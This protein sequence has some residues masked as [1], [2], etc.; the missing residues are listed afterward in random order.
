MIVRNLATITPET[1]DQ[2]INAI[3]FYKTIREQNEHQYHLLLGHSRLIHYQS[4]EAIIERGQKD[5]WSYFLI[6]GQLVV[7]VPADTGSSL[8]VNYI[9][10][11]EVFGDL[12]VLIKE[13][14]SADVSV[15]PNCREAV[16]FGT[17][18]S[19]FGE[20]EDC[21]LV[22]LPTKLIYYRHTI[23]SLRWKLEMYRSKYPDHPMASKHRSIKIY[24]GP[25]D[26]FDEL[27]TLHSNTV[28]MAQLLSEW[29]K[30]LGALSMSDGSSSPAPDLAV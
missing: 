28:Q 4:G 27:K 30:S 19:I 2:L 12:A 24:T 21:R 13:A 25:K 29:N 3:P 10:P 22:L 8:H 1:T 16:V 26:C 5:S 14:R 6:K 7:T 15:D 23:H 18:F 17:D 20:L 9:T 11:G